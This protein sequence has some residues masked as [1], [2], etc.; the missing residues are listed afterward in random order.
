MAF[1]SFEDVTY[2]NCMDKS[3]FKTVP[4]GNISTAQ[5]HSGRTSVKVSAGNTL[6]ISNTVSSCSAEDICNMTLTSTAM[7][8][9]AQINNGTGPYVLSSEVVSGS[10]DAQLNNDNT[11]TL[12]L[13]AGAEVFE[14]I[15]SLTDSTGCEVRY[16]VSGTATAYTYSII[17]TNQD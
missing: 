12:T 14:I 13:P 4:S 1:G 9:I 8:G 2:T 3:F 17:S 6:T 10:V 7:P 11:I 5:A 16:L 15:L